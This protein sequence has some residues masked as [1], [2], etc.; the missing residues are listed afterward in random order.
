M[1]I[2]ILTLLMLGLSGCIGDIVRGTTDAATG[3][4]TGAVDVATAPLP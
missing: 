4:A 3:I 1:K 2:I